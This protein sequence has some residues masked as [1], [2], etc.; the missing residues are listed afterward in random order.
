MS[1]LRL[2]VEVHAFRDARETIKAAYTAAE[3]AAE[4]VLAEAA[5][6]Q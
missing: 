2:Q 3:E 4:A 1:C 6:A 5:G